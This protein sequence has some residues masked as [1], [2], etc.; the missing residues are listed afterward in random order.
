MSISLKF[1]G[2]TYRKLFSN[3]EPPHQQ[4]ELV[5]HGRLQNLEGKKKNPKEDVCS[6][7]IFRLLV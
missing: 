7:L 1:K 2:K 6:A 4:A 3:L 5:V